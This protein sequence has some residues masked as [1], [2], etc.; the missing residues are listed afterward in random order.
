MKL[1]AERQ[2]RMEKET[3]LLAANMSLVD[4]ASAITVFVG[5]FV[6]TGRVCCRDLEDKM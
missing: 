3:L 1:D 2:P 4:P 5:V 6:Q